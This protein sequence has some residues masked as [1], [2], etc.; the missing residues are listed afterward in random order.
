[1]K[2]CGLGDCGFQLSFIFYITL[3]PAVT[4]G[5]RGRR[6][7]ALVLPGGAT[8]VFVLFFQNSRGV[9]L[10]EQSCLQLSEPFC[11]SY[12]HIVVSRPD[13]HSISG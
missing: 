3:L 7:G 9:N 5:S 1:M 2:T 8:L 13:N 12:Y 4:A 10:G 6:E 11:I